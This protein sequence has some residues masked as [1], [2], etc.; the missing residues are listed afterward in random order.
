MKLRGGEREANQVSERMRERRE[1]DNCRK[2]GSLVRHYPQSNPQFQVRRKRQRE[3]K[4]KKRN[5]TGCS[6]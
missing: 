1:E 3:T 4:G 6:D 2:R 5:K